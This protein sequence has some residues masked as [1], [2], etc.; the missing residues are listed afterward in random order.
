MSRVSRS[1]TSVKLAIDLLI[2]GLRL[3]QRE[4]KLLLL[5][6]L[7][8]AHL[9]QCKGCESFPRLQPEE[10]FSLPVFASGTGD[11]DDPQTASCFT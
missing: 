10:N 2:R 1:V 4:P 11:R 7:V 3:L 5:A 6:A 9:T 8:F